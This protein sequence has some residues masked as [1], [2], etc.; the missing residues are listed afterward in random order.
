VLARSACVVHPCLGRSRF[1][2]PRKVVLLYSNPVRSRDGIATKAQAHLEAH[3]KTDHPRLPRRRP[4]ALVAL[5]DLSVGSP[6]HS[7]FD[8]L[9]TTSHD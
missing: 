8:L 3:P 5:V 2:V 4:T 7:G 1:K 6:W 9:E